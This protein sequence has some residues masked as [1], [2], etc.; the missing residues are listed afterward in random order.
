[1]LP[2]ASFGTAKVDNILPV[3]K[4]FAYGNGSFPESS[5]YGVSIGQ[6]LNSYLPKVPRSL[7]ATTVENTCENH[8]GYFR[9]P[10]HHFG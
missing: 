8:R 5:V 10:S 6:N 4:L 7:R 9:H 2:F 3:S 1:M